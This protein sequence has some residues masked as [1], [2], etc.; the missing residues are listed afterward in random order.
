MHF[1]LVIYG[2]HFD[3][4]LQLRIIAIAYCSRNVLTGSQCLLV[5]LYIFSVITYFKTSKKTKSSNMGKIPD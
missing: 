1:Y 2:F 4:S 5:Q 3:R